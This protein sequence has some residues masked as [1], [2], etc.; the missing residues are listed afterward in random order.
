MAEE[1]FHL[2]EFFPF[3]EEGHQPYDAVVGILRN[4]VVVKS[5]CASAYA[6]DLGVFEVL[7]DFCYP[8]GRHY[9]VGVGEGYD[10][11]FGALYSC[12]PC[13]V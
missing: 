3:C 6:A 8:V 7:D 13:D 11:A 9:A 2:F 5:F 1:R 12:V 10:F 4:E